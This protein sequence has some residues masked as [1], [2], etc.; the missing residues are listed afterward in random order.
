MNKTLN[1][2]AENTLKEIKGAGLYKSQRVISTKQGVTITADGK[3][4]LNFCA[5]NYLGLSG[6]E[7]LVDAAKKALDTYGYGLSSVRFICGTQTI[8][9]ALE[10]QVASFFHKEASILFTSC[11]DANEGVFSALL[12]DQD[13]VISDAL[14]HAS[15]ID[16]IRLCKAER[17]VFKHMD[18]IDLEERLKETQE[19]RMRCIVTDG[20]FSMDGDI[21]PLKE[22]CDL[23]DKYDAFVVV[24]D[25]HASGFLGE[26]GRGAAEAAGVLDRVDVI[27]TTFGKALGGATGGA[28]V[29]SKEVVALLHQRARTTLFTNSLPPV[30]C[31]VTSYVLAYV[32]QHPE[33]RK[34]LWDNTRYFREKMATAGFTLPKSVHPIVPVI[35]GEAESAMKMAED[36]LAEGI[37]VIAF[38]YPV[39]PMGTARIRVQISASHTKEQINQLVV[40][41]EKLGKKYGIL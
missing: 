16:G 5:N 32:D 12:T 40:A 27:T 1:N 31:G 33:L 37:Y 7:D 39:V 10:K 35:I 26:T 20:V 17:H 13:A 2:I 24:D 36:M 11:W 15:L 41:F 30:I 3:E 23:A 18:M 14:N 8:H 22:I 19:K 4:L 29:A 28:V 21:A 6:R 25:A 38:S 9:E 34:T